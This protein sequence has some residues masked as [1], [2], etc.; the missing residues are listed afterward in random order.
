VT[1]RPGLCQQR[2]MPAL[3]AVG[4]PSGAVAGCSRGVD[5]ATVPIPANA[6][7]F[8]DLRILQVLAR[9]CLT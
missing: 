1:R 2:P 6:Q 3:V 4:E 8:F 7:R 9:P 5:T